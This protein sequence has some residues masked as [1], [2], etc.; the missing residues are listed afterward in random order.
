MKTSSTHSPLHIARDL[1]ETDSFS[2]REHLADLVRDRRAILQYVAFYK[3]LLTHEQYP[4]PE[5]LS[6]EERRLLLGGGVHASG[7]GHATLLRLLRDPDALL[8]LHTA[9]GEAPAPGSPW[10]PEHLVAAPTEA[11]P[12]HESQGERATR[13]GVEET[14]AD[15]RKAPPWVAALERLPEEQ[16]DVVELRYREGLTLSAIAEI[17]QASPATV[18]ARL[19]VGLA[20]LR[21]ELESAR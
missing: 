5:P 8:A 10:H 18:A 6:E 9:V 7:V 20:R 1:I 16:R 19:A 13:F 4:P 21:T 2:G 15:D 11:L 17:V 14:W 12:R 3:A